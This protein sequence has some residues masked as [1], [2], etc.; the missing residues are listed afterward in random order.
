MKKLFYISFLFFF[1]IA[2]GIAQSDSIKLAKLDHNIEKP[3][4]AWRIQDNS[5]YLLSTYNNL[6]MVFD[7]NGK[8]TK[9]IRIKTNEKLE[10]HDFVLFE[11]EIYLLEKNTNSIIKINHTGN[12]IAQK[13][14]YNLNTLSIHCNSQNIF[15][16]CSSGIV[17]FDKK[18]AFKYFIPFKTACPFLS[19]GKVPLISYIGEGSHKLDIFMINIEKNDIL[20]TDL[21]KA[22]EKMLI[23]NASTFS[24][25]EDNFY[26]HLD[27]GYDGKL[28]KI[29]FLKINKDGKIISAVIRKPLFP[30]VM[31]LPRE[32]TVSDK[33]EIYSFSADREFFKLKKIIL[34]KNTGTK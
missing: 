12:I 17:I 23:Y 8:T 30:F 14:L 2:A 3:Y 32:Y 26:L 19:D 18:I 33:G 20:K 28:L 5:I 10:L 11:K 4:T 6:I 21:Y 15:V 16:K 13:D 1:I 29:A 22:P 9:H 24:S 31:E 25:S 7:I 34:K 27:L